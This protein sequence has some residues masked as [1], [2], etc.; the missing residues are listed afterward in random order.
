MIE[1][2][3][4]QILWF[5]DTCF[6]VGLRTFQP[7]LV[8]QIHVS[9]P[10]DIKVHVYEIHLLTLSP[11]HRHFQIRDHFLI[12]RNK[13]CICGR[14]GD[15]NPRFVSFQSETSFSEF[16]ADTKCSNWRFRGQLVAAIG[17]PRII[18]LPKFDENI[19]LTCNYVI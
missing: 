8:L 6:M 17:S 2:N 1:F 13:H 19:R 10:E 11:T 9:L 4:Y 12:N 14:Q 5:C 3:A 7:T 15:P 18:L 16:V